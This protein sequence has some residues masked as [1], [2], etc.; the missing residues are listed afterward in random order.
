MKTETTWIS[1]HKETL[2]GAFD[3]GQQFCQF[4]IIL[5][6]PSLEKIFFGGFA[7]NNGA[8]QP[9]HPRRLISAFVIHFF[10]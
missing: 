9:A 1:A 8:D 7:N 2:S 3:R 5:Y 10:A 4:D 6:G